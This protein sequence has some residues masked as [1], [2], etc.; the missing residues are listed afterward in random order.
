LKIL[1]KFLITAS[2]FTI[3]L[4][5]F[6]A[7]SSEGPVNPSKVT[8]SPSEDWPM[9]RNNAEHTG[10]TQATV[11]LPLKLKWTAN[12]GDTLLSSPAISANRLF[13]GSFALDATTGKK[14]WNFKTDGPITTS[15]AVSG[16]SVFLGSY[17]MNIYSRDAISG[18]ELWK[19]QTAD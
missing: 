19:Y 10:V 12:A 9:F 16:N 13:V 11:S 1:S 18:K 14:L 3:I 5:L 17:E 8:V 2:L 15:P 6:T 7:C 4:S